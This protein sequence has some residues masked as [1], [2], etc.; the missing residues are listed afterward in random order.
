MKTIIVTCVTNNT[1]LELQNKSIQ[2]FFNT[3]YEFI[4]FDDSRE[5]K[6][7]ISYNKIQTDDI[8]KTCNNLNIKYVRIPQKLHKRRGEVLPEAFMQRKGEHSYDDHPVT[9][10]AL[11]VQFAFNYV[12]NNYKDCYLFILDSDMFFIDNFNIDIYMNNYDIMGIKQSRDKINYLWNGLFICDLLKC[13]NIN[14]FNW[15]AGSVN[16]LDEN[17]NKTSEAYSCDVGGHNYYYLKK[18]GYFTS[19][20]NKLKLEGALHIN[21]LDSIGFLDDKLCE[22]IKKFAYLPN[23]PKEAPSGWINKELLLNNSVIHIRGGGGWCYHKEE[24]HKEC[25]DLINSYIL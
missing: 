11:A 8:K 1:F 6:H 10:C 17:N 24:Y 19:K 18:E 14:N 13:N 22:F 21:T 3:D 15:E 23:I 12:I 4:V 9:R 25:V 5:I 7:I 20:N 2:K 16:V